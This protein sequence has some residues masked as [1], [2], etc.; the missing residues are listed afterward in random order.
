M[1]LRIVRTARGLDIHLS[2]GP[3]LLQYRAIAAR[4]AADGPG[5]VLDWGCGYGQVTSL[6]ADKG[7]DVTAFDYRDDVDEPTTIRLERFPE[8]TALASPDPVQLP[9]GSATFGAVLSCGVLEHVQ[10]PDASVDEIRRV[11]RRGGTFYV[12]N[13]PNRWSYTEK[14][15]RLLGRYYHGRLPH[16]RVYTLGSARRLLERHGF[17]IRELR[18]AHMLPLV[19]GGPRIVWSASSALERVPVLNVIA[20]TIEIVATTSP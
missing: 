1:I 16:D 8:L 19:L 2:S 6:L 18:R 7:L 10:D 14:A 11:L 13:L 15:A 17:T 9:F 5:P 12:Y 3:Q 20:T 4:I